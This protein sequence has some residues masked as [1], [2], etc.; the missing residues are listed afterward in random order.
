MICIHASHKLEL[1]ATSKGAVGADDCGHDALK[2]QIE[3]HLGMR[4]GTMFYRFLQ[5]VRG[6][7]GTASHKLEWMAMC[8]GTVGAD[9]W[10]HGALKRHIEWHGGMW[11]GTVL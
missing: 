4:M 2:R 8:K 7:R 6:A 5:L 9:D 11:M 3:R 1:M 10:G